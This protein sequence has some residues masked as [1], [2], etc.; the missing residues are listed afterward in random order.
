MSTS[1]FHQFVNNT[2][3]TTARCK[4]TATDYIKKIYIYHAD[5]LSESRRITI[6]LHA[7]KMKTGNKKSQQT[8][9]KDLEKESSKPYTKMRAHN[10]TS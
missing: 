9:Y 4:Q 8:I 2:I 6:G 3:I 1:N 10:V 7:F 5:I